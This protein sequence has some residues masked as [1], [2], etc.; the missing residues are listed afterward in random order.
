MKRDFWNISMR[1]AL[2]F[3]ICQ[4][5]TDLS[6]LANG[7]YRHLWTYHKIRRKANMQ[8]CLIDPSNLSCCI[9]YAVV[10]SS[11]TYRLRPNRTLSGIDTRQRIIHLT[12]YENYISK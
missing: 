5:T 7:K 2:N 1:Y 11:D 12:A 8:A 6:A 9:Q 4:P 10:I 3:S